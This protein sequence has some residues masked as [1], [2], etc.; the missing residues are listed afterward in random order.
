MYS[1]SI[2]KI[3]KLLTNLIINYNQLNNNIKKE[4]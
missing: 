1:S 3:S 2:K 4:S